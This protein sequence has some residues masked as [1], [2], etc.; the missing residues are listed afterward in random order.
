MRNVLQDW[1]SMVAAS[2]FCLFVAG[3]PGCGASSA[4]NEAVMPSVEEVEIP[5]TEMNEMVEGTQGSVD[6]GTGVQ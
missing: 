1:K 6:D 3:L 4:D 2:A 5:E